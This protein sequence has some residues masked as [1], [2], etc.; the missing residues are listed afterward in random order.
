MVRKDVPSRREGDH[1]RRKKHDC[2][3][4]ESLL[5]QATAESFKSLLNRRSKMQSN[6]TNPLAAKARFAPQAVPRFH[7]ADTP[8]TGA[9]K[10]KKALV[11]HLKEAQERDVMRTGPPQAI[12]VLHHF[13]AV[14]HWCASGLRLEGQAC[15]ISGDSPVEVLS[16]ALWSEQVVLTRP[17][18]PHR[19]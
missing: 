13:A 5:R 7:G 16:A 19:G 6:R 12:L 4:V 17:L 2:E 11:A 9:V 15:T 18:G 8:F 3:G 14:V 10:S 1:V